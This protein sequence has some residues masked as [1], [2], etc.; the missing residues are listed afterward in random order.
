[1]NYGVGSSVTRL[2]EPDFYTDSISLICVISFISFRLTKQRFIPSKT[3]RITM[4]RFVLQRLKDDKP[5]YLLK[6][7]CLV[8]NT[9]IPGISCSQSLQT[10]GQVCSQRHN[11]F[12]LCRNVIAVLQVWWKDDRHL[13]VYLDM[14]PLPNKLV[15]ESSKSF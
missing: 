1:M 12:F 13:L 15:S 14:E 10:R 11:Y 4:S 8:G 9:N 3:F 7:Q 2:W 5:N 6:G